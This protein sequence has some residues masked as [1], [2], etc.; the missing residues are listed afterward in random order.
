M[1]QNT[2]ESQ[3]KALQAII[4]K[5]GTFSVV[6]LDGSRILEWVASEFLPDEVFSES[7]LH[8]WAKQAGFVKT[9]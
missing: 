2:T 8:E 3:D 7:A 6:T 9:E 5:N 1:P 4:A